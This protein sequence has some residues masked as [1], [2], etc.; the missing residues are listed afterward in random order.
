MEALNPD[1]V[2]SVIWRVDSETEIPGWIASYTVEWGATANRKWV[3]VDEDMLFYRDHDNAV[4]RT[5]TFSYVHYDEIR[6][7]YPKVPPMTSIADV[8]KFLNS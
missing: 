7:A 4:N 5:G 3:D 2:Y 6:L 1:Q 8:D